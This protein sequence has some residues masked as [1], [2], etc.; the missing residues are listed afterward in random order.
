MYV[1]PVQFGFSDKPVHLGATVGLCISYHYSVI[2]TDKHNR[3]NI[4]V[5][6]SALPHIPA[7]RIS[8]HQ[9]GI[10]SHKE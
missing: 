1:P 8:H 3:P 5:L 6:N 2:L 9:A 7:V 10:G 4:M